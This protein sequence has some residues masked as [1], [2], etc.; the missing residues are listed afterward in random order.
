[1][2]DGLTISCAACTSSSWV[3]ISVE[4]RRHEVTLV[5]APALLRDD[6]ATGNTLTTD[7]PGWFCGVCQAPASDAEILALEAALGQ[8]RSIK[9]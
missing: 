2:T 9:A 1:M 5:T 8:A 4:H 6:D 7:E 3:R